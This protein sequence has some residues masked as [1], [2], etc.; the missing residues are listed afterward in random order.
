MPGQW[1]RATGDDGRQHVLYL[2]EKS[3]HALTRSC[4]CRPVMKDGVVVH[5]VLTSA[6]RRQPSSN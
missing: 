1:L 4:A 5:D 3:R 2:P 6:S